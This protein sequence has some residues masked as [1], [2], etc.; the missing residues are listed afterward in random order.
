M[1][2]LRDWIIEAAAG[3]A[4]QAVVLGDMGWGSIGSERIPNYG[5]QPRGKVLTW[6][7][8]EPWISYEFNDGFGAPGCNAVVAYTES[9]IISVSQYDGSTTKFIVQ[10]NPV[11]HMPDMPGG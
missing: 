5:D 3:E 9:K 6:D 10:R 2:V 8:A 1:A 11:D 7:E 4:V